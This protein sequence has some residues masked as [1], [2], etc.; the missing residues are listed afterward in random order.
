[1]SD[2]KQEA[3]PLTADNLKL[4]LWETLNDLRSGTVQ[5]RIADAIAGQAREITRIVKVQMQVAMQTK[6]PVPQ[7]VIEYT[8]K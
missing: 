8:G 1:M 6:A 5:P 4:A 3:K 7:A 2:E